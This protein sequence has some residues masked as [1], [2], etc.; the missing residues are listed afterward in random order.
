MT[1]TSS[2][3]SRHRPARPRSRRVGF[4]LV[5]LL[6]VIGIIGLLVSILLPSV[7]AVRATAKN[8]TCA[9]NE[10]QLFAAILAFAADHRQ[11]LPCPSR[12][13]DLATDPEV[14]QTCVWG[15]VRP[16]VA[17]L[18]VGVL[19]KYLGD[20]TGRKAAIWCPADNAEVSTAATSKAGIDRNMSYSFNSLIYL[21]VSPGSRQ[22]ATFRD[23]GRPS[24]TILLWE[25]VSP[26]DSYCVSPS[27]NNDDRP[28]GR[29]GRGNSLQ[30][31]TPE[32]NNA[33][34]A[35][36]GFFD[37]H[38]ESLT[39]AQINNTPTYYSPLK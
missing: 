22:A 4:T 17:S 36:F 25:E 26:N 13:G 10:R 29:H 35:N 31:G 28:A 15:M 16:G 1:T 7:G 23:V 21:N 12:T 3:R 24:G 30:Y 39:P 5:E 19:W 27:T 11:S 9:S 34:R 14:G 18:T 32:Y 8:A 38:V 37:G 33:G 20:V 6:V 2:D